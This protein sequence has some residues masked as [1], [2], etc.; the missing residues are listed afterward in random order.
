RSLVLSEVD[1]F[2]KAIKG[3]VHSFPST[4]DLSRRTCFGFQVNDGIVAFVD[5]HLQVEL[6]VVGDDEDRVPVIVCVCFALYR[7]EECIII[8]NL[9]ISDVVVK[10]KVFQEIVDRKSTRLNSSHV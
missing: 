9:A 5:I 10:Q 3:A 6:T 2:L 4:D 7:L 8:L 1:R